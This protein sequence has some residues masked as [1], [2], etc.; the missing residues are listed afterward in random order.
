MVANPHLFKLGFLLLTNHE[1]RELVV[2]ERR[3]GARLHLLLLHSPGER[4]GCALLLLWWR[5][6]ICLPLRARWSL[7]AL[8]FRQS[9]CQQFD[10]RVFSNGQECTVGPS[11]KVF[12]IVI[13]K[14]HFSI[15]IL[16]WE[17]AVQAEIWR[18]TAFTIINT[19]V[20]S[21]TMTTLVT[22]SAGVLLKRSRIRSL[23]LQRLHRQCVQIDRLLVV[24]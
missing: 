10:V 20:L 2:R 23:R 16:V 8:H 3:E 1:A 11:Y 24:I 5:S 19:L 4:W 9:T 22:I 13:E 18:T 15:T 21:M 12:S 14:H 6:A 17:S 7:S